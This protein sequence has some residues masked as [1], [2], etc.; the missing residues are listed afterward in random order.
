MFK[1]NRVFL[2]DGSKAP[3]ES[4]H[5]DGHGGHS[6]HHHHHHGGGHSESNLKAIFSFPAGTLKANEN[7]RINIQIKNSD[8]TIVKDF[9]LGHEKLMHLI[10]VSKDLTFFNHI[11]PEFDGAGEF[12]ID[13]TFPTG[14]E[15]KIIA[16]VLP[17][18]GS[19]TTLSEWVKVEGEAEMSGAINADTELMKIV[20]GKEVELTLSSMNANEEVTLTF[21]F[22]DTQTKEGINNLEQYLGAV[23]HVVIISEDANTY[24]HVHPM[25]EAE[26]GPNAAFMTDFPKGGIYKVWGQFQHQGNVFTVPFVV[27]IK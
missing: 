18:G 8:D 5:S 17:K 15:Y 16:D 11:H 6:H 23:G 26:T 20:D 7:A 12:T 25:N 2:F 10:V 24:L 1:L 3:Q 4:S 14:G 9:E 19:S 21:N 27:D 13:T 22:V